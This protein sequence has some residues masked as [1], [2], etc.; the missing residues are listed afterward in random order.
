[1]LSDRE[2]LLEIHQM[3]VKVC[4]YI[5]K[6]ESPEY[7]RKQDE[8]EFNS[9]ILA[10]ILVEVLNDLKIRQNNDILDRKY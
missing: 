6:V 7:Q 3:L 9:N 10:D 8:K 4:N 2:L 5:D 1:M